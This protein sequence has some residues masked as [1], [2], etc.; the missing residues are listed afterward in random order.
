MHENILWRSCGVGHG[1]GVGSKII[2]EAG[3]ALAVNDEQVPRR[4]EPY[5]G[6]N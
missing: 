4:V 3:M 2:R 6:V 5:T 1:G